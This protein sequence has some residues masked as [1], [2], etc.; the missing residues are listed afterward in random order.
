MRF[1]NAFDPDTNLDEL[2]QLYKDDA[3]LRVTSMLFNAL[4]ATARSVVM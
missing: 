2:R 1:C 4:L 3:G